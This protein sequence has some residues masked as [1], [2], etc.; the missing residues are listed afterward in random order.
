MME[1]GKPNEGS[2]MIVTRHTTLERLTH[3]ANI[4][5]ISILLATGFTVY[6]GLPFLNYRDAYAL[7]ILAAA[8]FVSINWIVIPY[9]AIVNGRLAEYWF[10]P[11]DIRRLG[12]ILSSFFSG[13]EY[14]RYTVY[15]ERQ[16]RF[17]N[18]LHPVT[19]MI[20]YSHYVA[21][22]VVTFTGVVLYSTTLTVL[23]VNVSGILLKVLDFVAPTLN[24]SGL[25]LA[26]LLHLAAAYWFIIEI[27]VHVGMVQLDPKKFIHL[28]SMFLTG[29]EDLM[30]DP[31]AEII[32]TVEE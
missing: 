28:K 21:L 6:L 3:Y 27:I 14:P 20:I 15:D 32:N 4:I 24:L 19:K 16:R 30:K 7:H 25:G 9:S 31:T 22:F 1:K 11:S 2:T 8:A 5:F 10:W 12:K 18:R 17:R 23:D 29:K 26:R 13:G